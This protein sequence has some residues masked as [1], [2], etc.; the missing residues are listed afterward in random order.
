MTEI[1]DPMTVHPL[2]TF[3]QVVFLK[4]LI[5][6]PYIEVGEY[7]YYH[8]LDDASEFAVRNVLYAFGSERLIIGRYCAIAW[9]TRFI[10]SGGNHPMIGV[11]TYPFMMFPGAWNE[12]TSDV[13]GMLPS[14]GDTVVG[15]NVWIGYQATVMPGVRIGDGAI[16]GAGSV[17]TADIPPYGIVGGNPARL[18]R[19][20]FT[21]DEIELLLRVAWWDWPVEKV[22]EH[23]RT[24]LVG[25]PAALAA[26][27]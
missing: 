2:G 25:D 24:I 12:A 5:T 18:I 22:T 6:V 3:T 21:P 9:G 23:A 15:N 19:Q 20:R 17:V 14:R 7:T 10:M 27:A 16:I 26:V 8:G 4:P 1:P 11:G 13:V